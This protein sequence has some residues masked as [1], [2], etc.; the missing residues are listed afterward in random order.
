MA[1]KAQ[2]AKKKSL[3]TPLII[4]VVVV[5]LCCIVSSCSGALI[6]CFVLRQTPE[7]AYQKAT[8]SDLF[9][10]EKYVQYKSESEYTEGFA[11]PDYPEYDVEVVNN[12]DVY[13]G[14][15]NIE[16]DSYHEKQTLEMVSS[17]GGKE[18]V[19]SEA[20]EVDGKVY[21]QWGDKDVEEYESHE[22]QEEESS[23]FY[24]TEVEVLKTLSG[25][26]EYTVLEDEKVDGEDC[27]HYE[28]TL[29]R[30]NYEIFVRWFSVATVE[31]YL[32]KKINRNDVE[33][34]GVTCELWVS[35]KTS[36]FARVKVEID[37]I[38]YETSYQ[39]ATFRFYYNDYVSTTSFMKWGEEFE[40]KAPI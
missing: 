29:S 28:V 32:D 1:E 15:I 30:E 4:I 18:T 5:L 31:D 22:E 17:V 2:T 27:Y 14:Q 25:D 16:K 21:M 24:V 34:E 10:T 33:V 40:I 11:A 35:K 7:K 3:A 8:T 19:D 37:R 36:R 23:I 20:W 13:D 12:Y 6:W 39:G 9:T 26:E 38:E